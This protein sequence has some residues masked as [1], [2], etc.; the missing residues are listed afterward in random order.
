MNK[1]LILCTVAILMY[2]CDGCKRN[3]TTG[4]R[5]EEPVP[6]SSASCC[7]QDQQNPHISINAYKEALEQ[8]DG[9]KDL[10]NSYDQPEKFNALNEEIADAN[11]VIQCRYY[12]TKDSAVPLAVPYPPG[13]GMTLRSHNFDEEISFTKNG[14]QLFTKTISKQIF[15]PKLTDTL[16]H[17]G[18]LI[19]SG[20]TFYNDEDDSYDFSFAVRIPLSD[21]EKSFLLKLKQDGSYTIHNQ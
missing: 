18:I 9:L 20:D 19:K 2:G 11:V 4:S 15:E 5:Q 6:D 13:R 14:R 7:G 10:I 21:Q 17:R 12:C 3:L 1:F 8:V 16:K